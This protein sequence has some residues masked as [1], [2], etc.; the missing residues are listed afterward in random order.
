MRLVIL[1][2]SDIHIK[3]ETDQILTQ[4]LPIAKTL[5]KHISNNDQVVVLISGDIA[6]SGQRKQYDLATTFLENIKKHINKERTVSISF[7]M[8]PGNHD[9]DFSKNP[10]R[11]FILKSMLT[12]DLSKLDSNIFESCTTHQEEY[13]SFK[14]R[15][16][17]NPFEEDKLWTTSKIEIGNKTV[18]FESINLSWASS[19]KE[20]QGKLLFPFSSYLDKSTVVADLRISL[21]HHPLNWLNQSSYREFRSSLRPISNFIFTGHEHAN[22]AI[23]HDDIESGETIII[24]A[25]V[26]QEGTIDNSSFG[27]VTIELANGNNNYYT[28]QYCTDSKIYKPQDEKRLTSISNNCR[29]SF[30]FSDSFL[31][32][33]D[34]CGGYF[35]H[36][37]TI[38]LRLSDVFVY[39]NIKKES[40]SS[41][42]KKTTISAKELL[43][44][45]KFTKGVI[46]GGEDNI[47]C[48]SL[49]YSLISEYA[50]N[51]FI[52]VLLKGSD[53]KQKHK[54]NI[55]IQIERAL[56]NQYSND[57]IV[58]NFE[59]EPV[60]KKILF[61]DDFDDLKIKSTSSIN[62]ALAYLM[63]KFEKIILTVDSMYE[64]SEITSIGEKSATRLFDHYKIQ[65][66]GYQK[67]TELINKWYSVGQQDDETESEIIG[68]CNIAEKMMDAVM[69]KS[70]ISPNPIFLLT[71]LQ[72]IETGQSTQLSDSALGHYYNF[73]LSES[74]LDVGV[75]AESIGKELDYAMHLARFFNEKDTFIITS[76]E[77]REFNKY[78]SDTWQET[79]FEKKESILIR[80][81]VLIKNGSDYEFRYLYNYYYLLGMYLSQNI[82]NEGMHEEI[83]NYIKHLY[84][85]KNANTILFL[86]HHSSSDNILVMMKNAADELFKEN[87][88]ADFNGGCSVVQ[89]LIKDAPQLE[90]NHKSPQ[91]NRQKLNERRDMTESIGPAHIQ[92]E[93]QE[94]LSNLNLAT[95]I[96][97]LFKTIDILS[98]IIKSNPTKFQRLKKVEIIKS[99]FLA[100]L[101]AL[102]GFYSFLEDNPSALIEAINNDLSKKSNNL[103][104][105]ER[106]AIAR[107][108]VSRLIQGISSGFIV[109]IAEVINSEALMPDIPTAIGEN[110]TLALDLIGLS[111]SLDNH[112][113][114]ERRKITTIYSRCEK[115]VIA[116]RVLDLLVMHR[117]HMFKTSEQDMQWLQSELKYDLNQQHG[118]SY[119][120]A[121]KIKRLT[122]S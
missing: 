81:R 121:N 79:N 73:L 63:D 76:D 106:D 64:V 61:I 16:E 3:N 23:N 83:K 95:K 105:T 39:P 21:M 55:D 67:R 96:T 114:L 20:Q 2:L 75:G 120:R 65:Q 72:S 59:Q 19:L 15:L 56:S 118:I 89:E 24:E 34:D 30:N 88:A 103:P 110:P 70:L 44:V 11:E 116:I 91:E 10:T 107:L 54:N 77:F 62:E 104:D 17:N 22:N 43:R 69:D 97:M 60:C 5:Y 100:P 112:K 33:L 14:N 38:N 78:F 25:G 98:Q 86:A 28:Y 45:D 4:D 27:I 94:E 102:Q 109:K 93:K 8:C 37:N 46:L 66:F 99:I 26:L 31:A 9:C 108:A 7:I 40:S 82:L 117:L 50:A 113:P 74:F 35:K 119:N 29:T 92:E 41:T 68:K 71:F 36:S 101:R 1:H 111:I 18:V 12:Q 84:V 115:N 52:P 90:Y 47:G 85:K 51:G 13:F 48:T 42:S 49:V 57:D 32:K 87:I 58:I 6:F 122:T 53:I 80:A